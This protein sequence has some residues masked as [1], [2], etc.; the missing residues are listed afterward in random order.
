MVIQLVG[1]NVPSTIH[2]RKLALCGIGPSA[3]ADMVQTPNMA[4]VLEY[5][6][7]KHMELPQMRILF[8]PMTKEGEDTLM[9]IER[10]SMNGA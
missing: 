9:V 8:F 1:L 5:S 2:V 6:G 4:G 7:A 10:E 3:G